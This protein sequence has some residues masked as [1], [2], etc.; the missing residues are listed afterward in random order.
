MKKTLDYIQKPGK[1]EGEKIVFSF[2]C[3]PGNAED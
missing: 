1:K 2:G 3:S